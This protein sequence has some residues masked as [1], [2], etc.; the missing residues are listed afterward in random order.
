M[1]GGAILLPPKPV[2]VAT[3]PDMHMVLEEADK[4]MLLEE[5]DKH[6]VLEEAVVPTAVQFGRVFQESC[7]R[8]VFFFSFFGQFGL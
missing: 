6:M 4:H 3:V 1:N 8:D 5:A 2:E 7:L